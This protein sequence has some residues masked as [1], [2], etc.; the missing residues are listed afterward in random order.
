MEMCGGLWADRACASLNLAAAEAELLPSWRRYPHVTV[1]AGRSPGTHTSSVLTPSHSLNPAK[2]WRIPSRTRNSSRPRA[3]RARVPRNIGAH[4]RGER[5][6]V[7]STVS[8]SCFGRQVC[9]RVNCSPLACVVRRPH[10]GGKNTVMILP[11][12]HLRKPCYDFYFLQAIEFGLLLGHRCR[13][14][15]TRP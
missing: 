8:P 10:V 2:P 13:C 6:F 3:S 9:G 1:K 15:H 12:V 7:R 11:Q 14:L 4:G 5:R